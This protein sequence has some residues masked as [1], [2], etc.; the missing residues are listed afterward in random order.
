MLKL[1][2][3]AIV[4]LGGLCAP[5]TVSPAFAQAQL[6]TPA[7]AP[8]P[9]MSTAELMQAA[10]LDVVFSQFGA[11]MTDTARAQAV[12]LNADL[13]K[14]WGA[15]AREVFS[16]DLMHRK[17]SEALEDK[18]EPED[19]AAFA[20]FYGSPFG[21]RISALER[22][23]TMLP[24]ADQMSAQVAGQALADAASPA[25]NAQVDEALQ[26]VSADL[27]AAM[28]RESMR[29]LLIGMAMNRQQGDIKVPWE[30]VERQLEQL[31]PQFAAELAKAQRALT[32]YTY[33]ELND[34]D[35]ETYLD[36]LRTEPAKKLFAVSAYAVGEI[37]TER[38]RIFGEALATRLGRVNV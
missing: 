33:A 11:A 27:S 6:Q 1:V 16:A 38:M 26:L 23:A 25:R 14:A 21:Q 22:R 5:A 28:M 35:I 34:A 32:F 18:F 3:A 30:E 8:A 24:A 9:G 2:F 20:Q 37:V 29:G 7:E 12:P 19:Y 31:M 4:G 17:L 13:L 36:F 10:S 15:A